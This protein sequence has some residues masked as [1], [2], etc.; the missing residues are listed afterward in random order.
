[1]AEDETVY[2]S[3]DDDQDEFMAE[4]ETFSEDP[5][6]VQAEEEDIGGFGG[7]AI[8]ISVPQVDVFSGAYSAAGEDVR[9]DS[10]WYEPEPVY[11][12]AGI[13]GDE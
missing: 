7:G 10:S 9:G 5:P 8:D 12:Y 2:E 1:M 11:D 4:D 6:D 3:D 13:E